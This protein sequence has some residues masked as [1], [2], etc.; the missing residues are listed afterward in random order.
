MKPGRV[1]AFRWADFAPFGQDMFNVREVMIGEEHGK[2]R[3]VWR[4]P[5]DK[6][7]DALHSLVFGWLAA[8]VL[9]LRLDF[10]V[11]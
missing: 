10:S 1:R 3:R 8:G 6:P 11:A 5:P 2:S 4:R 7:D 9:S